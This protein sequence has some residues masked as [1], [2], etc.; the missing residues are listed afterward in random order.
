[1]ITIMI[2]IMIVTMM[3][4]MIDGMMII[5]SEDGSV[6]TNLINVNN[7]MMRCRK[8]IASVRCVVVNFSYRTR[9]HLRL[10]K[11]LGLFCVNN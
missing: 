3:I 10:M 6:G 1:M 7:R 5:Q 9:N 8:M 4:I 11:H 2:M